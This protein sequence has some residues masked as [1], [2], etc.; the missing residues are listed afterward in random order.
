[1]AA[2]TNIAQTTP[3][4][5]LHDS[6]P[7]SKTSLLIKSNI[8]FSMLTFLMLL[9]IIYVLLNKLPKA[10]QQRLV[11]ELPFITFILEHE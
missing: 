10:R 4:E 11:K 9:S 6:A 1:M 8:F 5:A 3:Q 2:S 7:A